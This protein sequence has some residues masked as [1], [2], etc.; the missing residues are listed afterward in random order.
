VRLGGEGACV[1]SKV[2][3]G[4]VRCGCSCSQGHDE[5]AEALE[6]V[7][8]LEEVQVCFCMACPGPVPL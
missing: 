2:L 4:R 3:L 8:G 6:A 7:T 5:L 1:M